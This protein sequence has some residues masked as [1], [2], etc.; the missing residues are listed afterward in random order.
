MTD[1]ATPPDNKAPD[2]STLAAEYALRLLEGE[3]LAAAQA[4]LENDPKFASMVANWERRL[5]PLHAETGERAPPADLWSRIA[6]EAGLDIAVPVAS[7][8]NVADLRTKLRRWQWATGLTA[9]AAATALAFAV[10]PTLQPGQVPVDPPVAEAPLVASIPIG[11]TPLRLGVT[12]LPEREEMLVSASGL[13]ADGVHDHELWLVVGDGDVRSLGVVEPGAE[14]RMPVPK[15]MA[16]R[17]AAGST[18]A[19][20][21][22]DLGGAK[23]GEPGL[24]VAK[25]EFTAT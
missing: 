17:I 8:D 3:E 4:K 15:D 24:V 6:R 9:I 22:E 13:T 23:A 21:R 1:E 12:Y 25:G 2:R 10:M 20:S 11:D 7:N 5:A 16:D 19:L 18:L 14:R